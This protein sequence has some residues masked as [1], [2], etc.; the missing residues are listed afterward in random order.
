MAASDA[1]DE[2]LVLL[3]LHEEQRPATLPAPYTDN[4]QIKLL[5][6]WRARQE[7]NTARV[8]SS[9]PTRIWENLPFPVRLWAFEQ[10]IQHPQAINVS[11]DDLWPLESSL[12]T[13]NPPAALA[14]ARLR[15]GLNT[16]NWSL[17][18]FVQSL[19][20]HKVCDEIIS[21][22]DLCAQLHT[23]VTPHLKSSNLPITHALS[24]LSMDLVR[25]AHIPLT[26]QQATTNQLMELLMLCP[27][28]SFDAVCQL[29]PKLQPM[30]Y[31]RDHPLRY[32]LMEFFQTHHRTSHA[33]QQATEILTQHGWDEKQWV[34]LLCP[35]PVTRNFDLF[36]LYPIWAIHHRD[37]LVENMEEVI[38]NVPTQIHEV[39]RYKNIWESL[40]CQGLDRQFW[41]Q[42]LEQAPHHEIDGA[43]V[44]QIMSMVINP[45]LKNSWL[46]L[47]SNPNGLDTL[48]PVLPDRLQGFY[49]V[50]QEVLGGTPA[51]D[52]TPVPLSW[53]PA[54]IRTLSD[55]DFAYDNGS[56]N[57]SAQKLLDVQNHYIALSQRLL[58]RHQL[59]SP[60]PVQA[61][62]RKI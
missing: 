34:S 53:P 11:V 13:I 60:P 14:V 2:L 56:K 58:L 54:E 5:H 49:C 20:Q 43:V 1:L 9:V 36:H 30:D 55:L 22:S 37:R 59:P 48:L 41:N 31:G 51:P 6:A 7:R 44:G 39:N 12:S 21:Q 61:S 4:K 33:F 38:C 23:I 3:S 18:P 28:Q 46:N 25:A 47:C 10:K 45:P 57:F 52:N 42:H 62:K 8:L 50:L 26:D 29:L 17:P 24:R 15:E 32:Q 35:L 40:A 27:Q 19:G 16:P